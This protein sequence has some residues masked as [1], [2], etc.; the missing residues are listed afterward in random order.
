M[1]T[2]K[3]MVRVEPSCIRCPSTSSQRARFWGS[4]ISS[5][6]T[7]QGPTG[8]KVSAPLPLSQV[9]PRSICHSRSLTSL[10]MV[11]PAT[12]SIAASGETFFAR[13]PMTMASSTSQSVFT[14]LRGITTS[15][16]GPCSEPSD[17]RNMIGSLGIGAPV[18]AAWSA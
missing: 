5:W 8:P 3:I 10:Q 14:L 9:P 7:S 1:R 13:L 4:G 6:V 17:F 18:S 15:S 16:F 11:Y 2:S 12:W